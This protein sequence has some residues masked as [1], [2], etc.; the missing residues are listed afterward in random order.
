MPTPKMLSNL[1]RSKLQHKP[2]WLGKVIGINKNNHR[3][4]VIYDTRI[5]RVETRIHFHEPNDL[6][7]YD[8]LQLENGN[9]LFTT[10]NALIHEQKLKRRSM[11]DQK[12]I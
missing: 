2:R 9:V 6:V 7:L 8:V 4:A 1:L 3:T 11:L 5:K 10:S 12:V